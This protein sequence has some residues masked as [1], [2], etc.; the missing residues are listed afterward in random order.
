MISP[1]ARITVRNGRVA[2]VAD[3]IMQG[4][5]QRKGS[6]DPVWPKVSSSSI[7][8]HTSVMSNLE[9]DKSSYAFIAKRYHANLNAINN[10]N[11]TGRLNV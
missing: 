5:T 7:I 8:P 4:G 1:T 2:L 6:P 3:S 10:F 9:I 11:A